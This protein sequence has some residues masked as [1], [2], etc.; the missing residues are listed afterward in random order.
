MLNQR[1]MY[2]LRIRVKITWPTNEKRPA[3]HLPHVGN[4][5]IFVLII[6]SGE[7]LIGGKLITAHFHSDLKAVAAQVI[8]VLHTC[9]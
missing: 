2:T 1:I 9:K 3:T 8:E 6:I 7:V 4:E 5:G